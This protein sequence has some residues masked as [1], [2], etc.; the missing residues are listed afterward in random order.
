MSLVSQY[1]GNATTKPLSHTEHKFAMP[2]PNQY[3]LKLGDLL[4][5]IKARVGTTLKCAILTS[6][7][8]T[9]Q[10]NEGFKEGLAFSTTQHKPYNANLLL[11]YANSDGYTSTQQEVMTPCRIN[12]GAVSNGDLM[13]MHNYRLMYSRD[14]GVYYA[15]TGVRNLEDL[16]ANFDITN[17]PTHHIIR[18]ALGRIART[19]TAS[20]Q[21][22]SQR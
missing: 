22:V 11:V 18:Q 2:K 13:D 20:R 8:F 10:D 16:T 9:R 5:T 7:K 3:T 19:T 17:L 15:F 21:N 12:A 6:R 4:A 14:G 1:I